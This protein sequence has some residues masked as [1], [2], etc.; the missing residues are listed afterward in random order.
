MRNI[1]SYEIFVI[2]QRTL[3]VKL[4]MSKVFGSQKK[5]HGP[6]QGPERKFGIFFAQPPGK[7]LTRNQLVNL[8]K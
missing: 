7:E 3:N 1:A 4:W 6:F 2:F 8:L 5:G